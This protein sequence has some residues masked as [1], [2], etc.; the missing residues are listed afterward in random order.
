MTLNINAEKRV[1]GG[2]GYSRRLRRGGNLPA[3]LYG[4]N[5]STTPLVLNKKD[6]FN[7]LKSESGENT[8]FR[9][10][11]NSKSLDVMIKDYQRDVVTDE[12]LHVDLIE[13]AMDKY[14]EVEVPLV[15]VGE[16][17]GVK[18]E[19]GFMDFATREIE[20]ECLPKDIPEE[21]EVDVSELHMNQAIKVENLVSPPGVKILSDRQLV[22]AMVHPPEEEEVVEE[23]EMEEELLAEGEEPEVIG[24]EKEE[25]PEEEESKE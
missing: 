3:V 4:P 1:G 25:E 10:K 15:L 16:A 7:I 20:V 6:I 5:V 11:L 19:G 18:S 21:I 2:K 24:R 22:V 12:L 14:L 9:I 17:V 23:E 8:L 13:I